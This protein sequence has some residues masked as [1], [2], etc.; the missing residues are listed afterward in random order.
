QKFAQALYTRGVAILRF[1][2]EV[3]P[4]DIETFLRLL[5]GVAEA[6]RPIWE[7]LTAAGVINI[8]L[9][10]VN[11]SAV[12]VTDDLAAPPP[13]KAQPQSL[14]EEILRAL[15]AGRELS[16]EGQEILCREVQVIDRIT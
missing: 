8:H 7:E 3:Q 1:E 16:L 9:Q 10:S 15:V 13:S 12:Q 2:S 5:G 14:W 11:Y 6:R 4:Q